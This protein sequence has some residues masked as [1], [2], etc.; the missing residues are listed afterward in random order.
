MGVEGFLRYD[1]FWRFK[2]NKAITPIALGRDRRKIK[3]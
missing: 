3:N 2:K 1:Q